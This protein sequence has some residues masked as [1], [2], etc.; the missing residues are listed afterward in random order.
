VVDLFIQVSVN[1]EYALF[2]DVIRRP[3]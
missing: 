3:N 2:L 1:P